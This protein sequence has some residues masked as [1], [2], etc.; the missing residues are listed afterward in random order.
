MII[1]TAKRI[2]YLIDKSDK[3]LSDESLSDEQ[4]YF[5]SELQDT[6]I[7]YKSKVDSAIAS[8]PFSVESVLLAVVINRKLKKVYL[9]I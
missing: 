6:L 3:L 9:S 7:R 5:L 2:E 8:S 4:F 1:K